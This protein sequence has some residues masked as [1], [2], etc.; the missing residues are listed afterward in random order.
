MQEAKQSSQQRGLVSRGKVE[1]AVQP[2][3]WAQGACRAG[4]EQAGLG[5]GR[6]GAGA[7]W[8]PTGPCTVPPVMYQQHGTE[9]ASYFWKIPISVNFDLN[10]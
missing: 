6:S 1:G 5:A 9:G 8:G 3:P 7:L 2:A 4:C 10:N